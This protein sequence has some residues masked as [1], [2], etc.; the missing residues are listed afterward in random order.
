[1]PRILAIAAL[2]CVSC[3]LCTLSHG[4]PIMPQAPATLSW[5]PHGYGAPMLLDSTLYTKQKGLLGFRDTPVH[6]GCWSTPMWGWD[7]NGYYLGPQVS[8]PDPADFQL[9]IGLIYPDKS[10]MLPMRGGRAGISG[11]HK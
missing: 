4:D 3:A 11:V 9:P 2:F 10:P 6:V 8:H 7:T 5:I 1:M